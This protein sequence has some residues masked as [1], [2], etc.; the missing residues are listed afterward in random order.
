MKKVLKLLLCVILSISVVYFIIS[1]ICMSQYVFMT[2]D[3]IK[4][5]TVEDVVN[6][7]KQSDDELKSSLEIE[8][9]TEGS[10]E[11][12]EETLET[13]TEEKE[14]ETI[15]E[16]AEDY[17]MGVTYYSMIMIMGELQIQALC[18]SFI[19][20]I[21][22]GVICF[23]FLTDKKRSLKQIVIL[24][25]I[26]LIVTVATVEIVQVLTLVIAYGTIAFVPIGM[27]YI[28]MSTAV[29]LFAFAMNKSEIDRRQQKLEEQERKNQKQQTISKKENKKNKKK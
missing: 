15:N 7:S 5:G 6:Y 20:G 27:Q 19:V 22:I 25:A 17:P 10:I 26:N 11:K 8:E 9:N 1:N 4:H 18:V 21:I 12:V 29:F 16:L 3:F 23:M 14:Y 13:T 24:Y 28:L 2:T